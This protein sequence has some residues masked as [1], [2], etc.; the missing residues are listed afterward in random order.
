[1]NKEVKQW[2]I[3][4]LESWNNTFD[5]VDEEGSSLDKILPKLKGN[6]KLRKD[7]YDEIFFHLWQIAQGKE[8]D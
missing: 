2:L 4:K 6:R 1:M 5:N 7:D 8:D 3:D